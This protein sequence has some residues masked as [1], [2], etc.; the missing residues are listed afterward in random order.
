[1]SKND[2]SAL[3]AKGLAAADHVLRKHIGD[4][5]A[6]SPKAAHMHLQ[7][8]FL[9]A[10]SSILTPPNGYW[11]RLAQGQRLGGSDNKGSLE[12]D[13]M[14]YETRKATTSAGQ[15]AEVL[16]MLRSWQHSARNSM[17]VAFL[18]SPEDLS[19]QDQSVVVE[20]ATA[21]IDAQIPELLR[22]ENSISLRAQREQAQA[23]QRLRDEAVQRIQH[24][25]GTSE[26]VNLRSVLRD[27][28]A[29]LRDSRA[30][31]G[32]SAI[33]VDAKLS[34][35]EQQQM[36]QMTGLFMQT[37]MGLRTA[38]DQ[39]MR[40]FLL[41]MSRRQVALAA[42]ANTPAPD[43][44]D[45]L[46]DLF[47]KDGQP[48]SV[49]PEKQHAAIWFYDRVRKS[50]INQS[51]VKFKDGSIAPRTD[52]LRGKRVDYWSWTYLWEALKADERTAN[53][54][55]ELRRTMESPELRTF[56]LQ[57]SLAEFGKEIGVTLSR[58]SSR[59]GGSP[60]VIANSKKMYVDGWGTPEHFIWR[61]R[62]SIKDTLTQSV[63]SDMDSKQQAVF[64]FVLDK[65]TTSLLI[66][67]M[68]LDAS[69]LAKY[70]DS[71]L[72]APTLDVLARD[73]KEQISEHWK[74]NCEGK[75]WYDVRKSLFVL[76]KGDTA[77]DMPS[78]Y[79]PM[80]HMPNF[81][82]ALP[83]SNIREALA[84]GIVA[85]PESDSFK[86]RLMFS[87]AQK[88]AI[89]TVLDLH[90]AGKISDDEYSRALTRVFYNSEVDAD[91]HDGDKALMVWTNSKMGS[92][93]FPHGP[94]QQSFFGAVIDRYYDTNFTAMS[95]RTHMGPL[96]R[97]HSGVSMV[98]MMEDVK[99]FLKGFFGDKLAD[100]GEEKIDKIFAGIL[101]RNGNNSEDK[102]SFIASANQVTDTISFRQA[103]TENE[104]GQSVQGIAPALLHE[105]WH[106]LDGE[107]GRDIVEN[108]R[109]FSKSDNNEAALLANQTISLLGRFIVEADPSDAQFNTEIQSNPFW[110]SEGGEQLLDAKGTKTV[111]HCSSIAALA[112]ARYH[113]VN[114]L[115]SRL[116]EITGDDFFTKKMEAFT[117]LRKVFYRNEHRLFVPNY[118]ELLK[119]KI[120]ADFNPKV[121]SELQ[122]NL[123]EKIEDILR[124]RFPIPLHE[125]SVAALGISLAKQAAET[126][127]AC[128]AHLA[129]G[130]RLASRR[131]WVN[132]SDN[133]SLAFQS[134]LFQRIA[135]PTGTSPVGKAANLI[136]S[137]LPKDLREKFEQF[138]PLSAPPLSPKSPVPNLF[139]GDGE[140]RNKKQVQLYGWLMRE[141]RDGGIEKIED[142]REIAA[143]IVNALVEESS[144]IVR[145]EVQ[146]MFGFD[147][148]QRSEIA[149]IIREQGETTKLY[150]QA[151]GHPNRD[152][153]A[154]PTEVTARFMEYQGYAQA[155][156]NDLPAALDRVEEALR[157]SSE[158]RRQSEQEQQEARAA[159][160]DINRLFPEEAQERERAREVAERDRVAN[161]LLQERERE[162]ALRRIQEARE[163]HERYLQEQSR[164]NEASLGDNLA[165]IKK[166]LT[167]SAYCLALPLSAS[168][169]FK[170]YECY[171][172]AATA[173]EIPANS[174]L[175]A[176]AV[177]CEL[178]DSRHGQLVENESERITNKR[179]N[180]AEVK[181]GLESPQPTAS[182]AASKQPVKHVPGTGDFVSLDDPQNRGIKP[183]QTG[184]LFKF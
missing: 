77:K 29:N 28:S 176:L 138:L 149:A 39:S 135:D 102:D 47:R 146:K 63:T 74:E 179:A 5:L 101:V 8:R 44:F 7:T 177:A 42:L 164:E 76:K 34:L 131:D 73:I 43:T 20:A 51:Q 40:G 163:Q 137:L 65:L 183:G 17:N 86:W 162:E 66:N 23:I 35:L 125:D 106:L 118:R 91:K 36:G 88:T 120:K 32:E 90:D 80:H 156:R 72:E 78:H 45:S 154:R 16:Y 92:R 60:D 184:V 124:K 129:D 182:P 167:R 22:L 33:D 104:F 15:A 89:S 157:A 128:A 105:I 48:F 136:A 119:A 147:E 123:S 103:K 49:S 2:Y 172:T 148:S 142:R 4:G 57:N 61:L 158:Q 132:G 19:Q 160:D 171:P 50:A 153:L 62:Q 82:F 11:E 71:V 52:T 141:M 93:D 181:K 116:A 84:D 21:A 117:N 99:K 38:A 169:L 94:P 159:L 140:L 166:I 180:L 95:G 70:S 75:D 115:M 79:I 24:H 108:L 130:N 30:R 18:V 67:H 85:M 96:D 54:P 143:K 6:T 110:M 175:P 178:K 9:I 83:K 41:D 97:L 168:L 165:E 69:E 121:S 122:K 98:V 14:R 27:I 174:V 58:S 55:D 133:E 152:Y 155:L 56:V 112:P 25:V 12:G 113:A 127:R 134:L 100:V 46:N 111:L 13:R 3:H 126:V 31:A 53:L 109:K 81:V 37:A 161:V 151:L 68:S 64:A 59:S 150:K 144:T 1:M 170:E 114:T 10:L 173:K 139:S 26:S 87:D 145:A 107:I